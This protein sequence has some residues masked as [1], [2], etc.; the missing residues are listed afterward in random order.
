M[1]TLIYVLLVNICLAACYGFYHIFLRKETFHQLNRVYLLA[2]IALCYIL[3]LLQSETVQGL[4]VTQRVQETVQASPVYQTIYLLPATAESGLTWFDLL[5]SVYAAGV[6]AGGAV[7][8]VSVWQLRKYS[9]K[10]HTGEAWSFFGVKKVDP[11]LPGTDMIAEHEDVHSRQGHSVDVMLCEMLVILN[12]FNPAAYFLRRALR[13]LHEYIADANASKENKAAYAALL[14]SR[15]FSVNPSHLAHSFLGFKQVKNRL[16]MIKRNPSRKSAL[17]K[18]GLLLPVFACLLIL[19]A[20]TTKQNSAVAALRNSVEEFGE[21]EV[22]VKGEVIPDKPIMLLKPFGAKQDTTISFAS[23]D[24][25]PEPQGGMMGFGKYIQENYKVP[26]AAVKSKSKGGRIV[27]SFIVEADGKLSNVKVVRDMGYGTGEEAVRVLEKMPAWTP[28]KQKGEAVRVAYTLPIAIT[29]EGDNQKKDSS[30]GGPK[31]GMNN[32]RGT[33]GEESPQS[34]PLYVVDGKVLTN[35]AQID[36]VV[37]N[38]LAIEA[39]EVLHEGKAID[40]YGEQ[41]KNGVIL[42]TTK[43]GAKPSLTDKVTAPSGKVDLLTMQ[44][45]TQ[46]FQGIMLIDGKIVEN[47]TVGSLDQTKIESMNI[48]KPGKDDLAIKTYPQ[49]QGKDVSKGVIAITTKKN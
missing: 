25:L 39:I 32:N 20:A 12:W 49:L 48:F 22:M 10:A 7:L 41:G 42:V 5:L 45:A 1:N 9:R 14:L 3:P 16:M 34:K 33:L 4:L 17:L 47:Q 29:L 2:A 35:D 40:Q 18:Y 28:G 23:V 30:G 6:L 43:N 37:K 13:Q 36:K 15:Q 19:S 11:G 46:N 8:A 38:T 27:T 21:K 44:N 31:T 26:E 24:V